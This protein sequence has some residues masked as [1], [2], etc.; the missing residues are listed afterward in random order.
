MKR[1]VIP[2]P[3]HVLLEEVP[4]SEQI[5][6]DQFLVKTIL[7]GISAG[8]ELA[9]YRGTN[10]GFSTGRIRYPYELVG[11]VINTGRKVKDVKVGDKIFTCGPHQELLVV[12]S[13]SD[14]WDQHYAIL[15]QDM[16]PEESIFTALTTTAVH[17]IHQSEVK[18]GEI[19]GITGLGVVGILTSQVAK[20]AGASKVI[21]IDLVD[22]RLEIA[23]NLGVDVVVN[24]NKE[25]V[26]GIVLKETNS[27]GV[28]IAIEASGASKAVNTALDI[29]RSRGLIVVLGFHTGPLEDVILG[30]E[31][32]EKELTMKSSRI[33]G[34]PVSIPDEYLR[35]N[36]LSN[37]KEAFRLIACG[38]VKGPR[39]ITHRFPMSRIK[40]AYD[41]LDKNNNKVLQVLLDWR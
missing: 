5:S 34:G 26:K 40:Q 14:N 38:K 22:F 9:H 7:T 23:R 12:D 20:C 28:D 3:Y 11:E 29:V 2:K 25:D 27:R 17:C 37:F 1:V 19:V 41:Y 18:Q 15:P 10:P 21:G 33:T 30:K 8:T 13:K 31:F 24:P 35:W 16:T 39:M 4:F 36:S 6:E 32:W